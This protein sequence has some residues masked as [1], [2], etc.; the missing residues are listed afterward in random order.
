MF[1]GKMVNQFLCFLMFLYVMGHR[2][3]NFNLSNLV[4]H[5]KKMIIFLF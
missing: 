3:H 1:Y 4:V 2:Q 5:I